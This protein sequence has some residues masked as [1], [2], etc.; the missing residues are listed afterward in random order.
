M[1]LKPTLLLLLL[2]TLSTQVDLKII[3]TS[4]GSDRPAPCASICAGE[5]G[6]NPILQKYHDSEAEFFYLGIDIA[7]CGFVEKPIVTINLEGEGTR[8]SRWTHG[9]YFPEKDQIKIFISQN[10]MSIESFPRWK[11]NVMWSAFGY[12]C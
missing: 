5:T 2:I 6:P 1:K 8:I 9:I 11:L 3:Q 10:E 4:S 12:T 7:E